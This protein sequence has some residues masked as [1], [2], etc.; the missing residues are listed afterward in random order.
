MK[1]VKQADNHNQYNTE[2][3]TMARVLTIIIS[4]EKCREKGTLSNIGI[5]LLES[6]E[7]QES[8]LK[9]K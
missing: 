6:L 7:K 1:I 2:N 9:I 5:Q 4:L 3:L 8:I